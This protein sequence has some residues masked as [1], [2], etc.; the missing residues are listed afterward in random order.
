LPIAPAN[1]Q[2][3]TW[4]QTNAGYLD[5]LGAKPNASLEM[6]FEYADARLA[7]FLDDLESCGKLNSTLL[8]LTSKQ[9]QGPINA[10]NETV[11]RL[12][13]AN[14]TGSLLEPVPRGCSS[15]G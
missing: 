6:A 4:A 5:A 3:I 1:F 7:T 9:G 12:L 11:S 13:V 2:A 14:V 8:L 15:H 10:A